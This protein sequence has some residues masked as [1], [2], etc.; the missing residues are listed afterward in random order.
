M[1]WAKRQTTGGSTTKLVLLVLADYASPGPDDGPWPDLAE[2]GRHYLW[3]GMASVAEACEMSESTV[4]RHEARLIDQGLI[5]KERRFAKSG[6][7]LSDWIV[8][9]CG[10]YGPMPFEDDPGEAPEEADHP[11]D[12]TSGQ[13]DPGSP[14]VPGP[15]VNGDLHK[16]TVVQNSK[17]LSLP[18]SSLHNA[19]SAPVELLEEE[20]GS[21]DSTDPKTIA[22]K[23]LDEVQ[24]DG[25]AMRGS[26]LRGRERDQLVSAIADRLQSGWVASLVT[27]ALE[28]DLSSVHSVY[29]TLRYRV[30]ERLAGAPP[31]AA[32]TRRTAPPV[33]TE[34]CPTCAPFRPGWVEVVNDDPLSAA[35]ETRPARCPTCRP[36]TLRRAERVSV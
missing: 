15:E 30:Q 23:I 11:P 25:G 19:G 29:G 14:V 12:P 31:T 3:A 4:K 18:S 32:P 5:R 24:R 21:E 17:D 7:R 33:V 27:V 34:P 36:T 22:G 16:G 35:G 2:G 9:A 13:S 6:N 8:L 1:A 26:R 28:G 20:E 10:E